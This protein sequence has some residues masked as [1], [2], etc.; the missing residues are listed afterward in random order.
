MSSHIKQKLPSTAARLGLL[1]LFL[2]FELPP[3]PPFLLPILLLLDV[4]RQCTLCA[5]FI[6]TPRC[7]AAPCRCLTATAAKL[8]LALPSGC[9]AGEP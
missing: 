2:L 6:Y 8:L 3:L 5:T 7:A 4:N 1:L 9:P